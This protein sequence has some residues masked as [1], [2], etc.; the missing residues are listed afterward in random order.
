MKRIFVVVG[1]LTGA[2]ALYIALIAPE[3]RGANISATYS[4]AAQIRQTLERSVQI[5][6]LGSEWRVLSS[7]ECDQLLTALEEANGPFDGGQGVAGDAWGQHFQVAARSN[8]GRQEVIVWSNG[9]DG[10]SGTT[11]D[12]VVPR[13]IAAEVRTNLRGR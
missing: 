9:P 12:I 7:K 4:A 13:E 8:N 1:L 10:Q 3:I 6:N 2:I 11:D 5:E